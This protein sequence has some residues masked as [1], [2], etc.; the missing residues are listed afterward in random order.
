MVEKANS[1]MLF[2]NFNQDFSCV[3]CGFGWLDSR[4][5]DDG[6][7]LVGQVYLGGDAQGLQRDELRSI[8]AGVHDE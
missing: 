8:R 4:S 2:A 1:N 7:R 6:G 5:A 3:C